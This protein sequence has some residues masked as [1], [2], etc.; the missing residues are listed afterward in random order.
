[1]DVPP[2]SFPTADSEN[3]AVSNDKN[4]V[5]IIRKNTVTELIQTHKNGENQLFYIDKFFSLRYDQNVIAVRE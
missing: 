4:N 3:R 1:M 2:V 5:T